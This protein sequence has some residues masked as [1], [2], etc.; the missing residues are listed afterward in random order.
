MATAQ[1]QVVAP[2]KLSK[3]GESVELLPI[4]VIYASSAHDPKAEPTDVG[5]EIP[6][7]SLE[8]VE[9]LDDSVLAN[10]VKRFVKER[11]GDRASDGASMHENTTHTDTHSSSMW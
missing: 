1:P 2:S 10:A 9:Q 11:H 7:L 6:E 3:P 8:A 4:A 5:I